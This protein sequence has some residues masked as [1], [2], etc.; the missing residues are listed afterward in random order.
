MKREYVRPMFM[1]EQFV[2]NEY[3]ATCFTGY[4]DVTSDRIYGWDDKDNDGE[5]DLGEEI[6]SERYV[7]NRACGSEDYHTVEGELKDVIPVI[8]FGAWNETTQEGIL[9]QVGW[10]F[11]GATPGTNMMSTHVSSERPRQ[12]NA[13]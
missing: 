13:S 4:C 5:Y 1:A 11:T 3:V 2:A 7:W 12:T 6:L 9:A 10:R 8:C